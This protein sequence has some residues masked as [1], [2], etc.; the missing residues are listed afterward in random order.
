MAESSTSQAVP[1]LG[2]E[3]DFAGEYLNSTI[4]SPE[5]L[6]LQVAWHSPQFLDH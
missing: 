4:E 3:K 5:L 1:R 6:I 2:H